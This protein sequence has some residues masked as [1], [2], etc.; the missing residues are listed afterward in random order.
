MGPTLFMVIIGS[1]GRNDV[2]QVPTADP[3][4]LFANVTY[5][6]V[7]IADMEENTEPLEIYQSLKSPLLTH[8]FSKGI[9]IEAENVFTKL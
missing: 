5:E 6:D 3:E 4:M 7:K 1:V 8:I 9:L 2:F